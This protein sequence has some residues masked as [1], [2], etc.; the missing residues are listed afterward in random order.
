MS[1]QRYIDVV[2]DGP[3]GPV[4]GRF[5]EVEDGDGFSIGLGK[6]IEGRRE[7]VPYWRL[8]M[9]DPRA[10]AEI[11]VIIE[12]VDRRCMAADGPVTPTLR[13]MTQDELSRIYAL[14]KGR[15]A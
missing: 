2:F 5:V 13:E 12:A 10:L 1:D 3:P 6:W 14:A 9:P 7:D 11:A 15:V 8:R 4:A